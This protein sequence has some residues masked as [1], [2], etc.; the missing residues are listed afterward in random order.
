MSQQVQQNEHFTPQSSPDEFRNGRDPT[1]MD[2]M[3][4]HQPRDPMFSFNESPDSQKSK[5]IQPYIRDT[6]GPDS[7]P[8]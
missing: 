6:I 2:H 1:N 5:P 8:H 4:N 3:Y 7:V